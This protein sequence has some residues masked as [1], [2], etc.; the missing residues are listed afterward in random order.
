MTLAKVNLFSVFKRC[1][2]RAII[3]NNIGNIV[4][5]QHSTKLINVGDNQNRNKEL[6]LL[7][8]LILQFY[9]LKHMVHSFSLEMMSWY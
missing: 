7:W 3:F 6:L 1:L 8:E 4:P 5:K 2:N 9:S